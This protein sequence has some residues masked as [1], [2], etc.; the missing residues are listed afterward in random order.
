MVDLTDIINNVHGFI[1]LPEM[2][3][4]YTL[5]SRVPSGGTVVEI[6]SYQ[7][8]STICLALGAKEAGALLYSI[9]PH[10]T[11]EVDGTQYSMADNQAYYENIAKYGVGDVVKTINLSSF[12]TATAWRVNSDMIDLLWID[13]N[14]SYESVK[15]DFTLWSWFISTTGK[16]AMHDTAGHH[17]TVSRFVDEML[18]N[19]VW[20][21]EQIID[22]TSIFRRKDV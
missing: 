1:S 6:G 11:Y 16:I 14:H 3:L 19:G 22:A 18:A 10:D 7:G 15:E 21:R 13:G 2:E 12:E 17:V 9:D 5:A 20:I 8:R 4:L